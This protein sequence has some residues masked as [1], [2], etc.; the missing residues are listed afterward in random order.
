MEIGKEW[1]SG[2]G[3]SRAA[4]LGAKIVKLPVGSASN[5]VIPTVVFSIEAATVPSSVSP[6][7]FK[8]VSSPWR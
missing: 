1:K 8:A 7:A 6:E 3:D 4:S 5:N 2:K